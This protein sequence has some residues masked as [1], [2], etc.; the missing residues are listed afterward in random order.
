MVLVEEEEF[1]TATVIPAL[2]VTLTMEEVV[3]EDVK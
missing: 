3:E 1:V 2:V